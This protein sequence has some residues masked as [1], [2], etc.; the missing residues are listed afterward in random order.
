MV[1][2]SPSLVGLGLD[3][4]TA[5]IVYADDTLEVVGKGSV[6]IVDG[7]QVVTDAYQTKGHRPMMVSGAILHSLPSGYW[8]DLEARRVLP[9]VEAVGERQL[10][11][12]ESARKRLARLSR[13]I[14]AEGADSFVV[15]RRRRRSPKEEKEASE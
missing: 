9:K 7:S 4:D 1:A 5:A 14:A 6:T 11:S 12:V 15:E 2:Q 8:F 10:K 3:E 13:E